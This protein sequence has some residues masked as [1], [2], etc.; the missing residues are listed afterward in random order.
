MVVTVLHE[1]VI[2]FITAF[3]L[4]LNGQTLQLFSHSCSRI[5]DKVQSSCCKCQHYWQAYQVASYSH[6]GH[7][8]IWIL[9]ETIASSAGTLFGKLLHTA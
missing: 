8:G 4:L 1:T 9:T 7:G 2:N 5:S 6:P 3:S